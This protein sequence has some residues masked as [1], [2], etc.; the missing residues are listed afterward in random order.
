[1]FILEIL[2]QWIR[3]T[4]RSNR[5]YDQAPRTNLLICL[6][7]LVIYGSQKTYSNGSFFALILTWTPQARN[8][9]CQSSSKS[10][11]DARIS[12]SESWTVLATSISSLLLEY[13]VSQLSVE[14]AEGRF[15]SLS[16]IISRVLQRWLQEM[17]EICQCQLTVFTVFYVNT[18][19]KTPKK[20]WKTS[21]LGIGLYI[22]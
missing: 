9:L 8:R 10:S 18:C 1:M 2:F 19:Q 20:N 11:F 14:L 5:N 3:L 16:Y 15:T 7:I 21:F 4:V 12:P 17:W 13:D 6:L 22:W